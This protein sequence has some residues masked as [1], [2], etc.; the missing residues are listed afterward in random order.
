MCRANL[1]EVK[2]HKAQIGQL[3][4]SLQSWQEKH[5][6]VGSLTLARNIMQA[7]SRHLPSEAPNWQHMFLDFS[8]GPHM[9][10]LQFTLTLALD[11]SLF[12]G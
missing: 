11:T 12:V 7:D 4:L 10:C 8:Q 2:Q 9:L 3:E 6:D 5:K 1:Q